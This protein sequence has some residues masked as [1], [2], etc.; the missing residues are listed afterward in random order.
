MEL[1]KNLNE[2]ILNRLQALKM[3][4]SKLARAIRISPQYLGQLMQTENKRK[5]DI[6]LL[7]K[8]LDVLNI[9]V[10][11][12]VGCRRASNVKSNIC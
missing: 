6:D 11:I 7:E 4:K 3:S 9:S 8:A 12:K 2:T 5:W 10:V 1:E